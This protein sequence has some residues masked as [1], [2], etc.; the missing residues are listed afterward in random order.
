M[1]LELEY[2]FMVSVKS[3]A[4]GGGWVRDTQHRT[5]HNGNPYAIAG[6]I[7]A[8]SMG[9]LES[10]V[11]VVFMGLL[12]VKTG[13]LTEMGSFTLELQRHA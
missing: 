9:N 7:A 13:V 5:P 12:N 3:C 11:R 10:G 4:P 1:K 2:V 6:R 8:E